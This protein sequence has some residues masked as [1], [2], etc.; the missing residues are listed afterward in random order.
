MA[1]RRCSIESCGNPADRSIGSCMICAK[2]LCGDHLR[3]ADAHTC[4]SVDRDPEAYYAALGAA[5]KH[6]LEALLR[7]INVKA[8]QSAASR[9]RQDIPCRI[10]AFADHINDPATRTAVVSSQCGGQ[11]CHVDIEFADGVIWI[12]R[13]RLE[14]PLLPPPGVQARIFMSEVATFEFLARTRVPAPRVYGYELEAPGNFVGTSYILME[15][16]A[17]KPLDWNS[18]N[19]EQRARVMEQLADVYLELERHPI[20]LA[21]SLFPLSS[22]VAELGGPRVQV[23]IFA[24]APCFETPEQDGGLGP[25]E[26]LEAAYTALIRQ[27]LQAIANH[28]ISRLPVDNYLSF[29][30]QLNALS[31]LVAESASRT[32]PFYLKHFDDKGDHILIDDDYNITGLIDWEFASAEAKELAFSSP[33]MMWSVDEFFDGDNSLSEDEVRFAAIFE[34]RGRR[35]L[36]EMVRGGRRWQR[37]LLFLGGIPRDMAEFEALFQALRKSFVVGEEESAAISSYADWK[38]GA[39]TGFAKGDAQLQALMQDERGGLG[40]GK[41]ERR[42]A[43]KPINGP[44][45]LP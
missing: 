43:T 36:G 20:P 17:G 32:G 38:A 40:G 35:D 25:F 22:G 44:T 34:Q 28:E 16:L 31:E 12:A 3:A 7:K 21:G 15:K 27:Q 1:L 6:H 4:P 33:C 13:I 8:L 41:A 37:Y 23:G 29:L 26:T 10:P 45:M 18:A 2:H 14:H 11:N 30:W 9:A 39:L 19:A 5:N 42:K 24:Q